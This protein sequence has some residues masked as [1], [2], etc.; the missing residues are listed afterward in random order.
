MVKTVKQNVLAKGKCKTN[1]KDTSAKITT[2][3]SVPKVQ[4]KHNDRSK[5][6]AIVQAIWAINGQDSDD[7]GSAFNG[8]TFD[9]GLPVKER[10]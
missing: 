1:P 10:N 5:V 8:E 3:A 6:Q 4:Q 7:S 9:L 2:T